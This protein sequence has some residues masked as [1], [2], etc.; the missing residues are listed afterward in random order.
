MSYFVSR[1]FSWKQGS[2][3]WNR[4][5]CRTTTTRASHIQ[6]KHISDTGLAKVVGGGSTGGAAADDD[7]LVT[8]V[9]WHFCLKIH[10]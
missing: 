7:N 1:F 10:F 6:A 9:L 8:I 5:G 4:C 3:R 2:I